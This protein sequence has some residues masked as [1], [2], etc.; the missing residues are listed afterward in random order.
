MFHTYDKEISETITKLASQG[1]NLVLYADCYTKQIADTLKILKL[2]NVFDLKVVKV[3]KYAADV[4]KQVMQNA[5]Y[6]GQIEAINKSQAVIE[7]N[8]DGTIINAN[9]NFLNTMGYSLD[10]ILGQH[11]RMFVGEKYDNSQEY[12]DFWA[13]LNRGEYQAAEYKRYGKDGKEVWIQA[14]YNPTLDPS[15]K[16]TKVVKY[17]IDITDQV[18]KNADY[19]GQIEAINKAQAVIEFKLDGTIINANENFLSVTGYTLEEV[20]GNH[21]SMFVEPEYRKSVEY[22]EFWRSL[23]N[24]EYQADEYKRLGKTGNEIWI[25]ASYNPI[26]DP[27]G[28]P[29]KVVK[30]ATDITKQVNNRHETQRVGG[31]VDSNLTQILNSVSDANIQATTAASA[32]TQTLQ[33]V[34]SVAAAVEEFQAASQEIARNM[35]LSRQEVE[36]VNTEA[37]NA[38]Q[39]CQT[40]FR[41]CV[42]NG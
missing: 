3:I 9:E 11:H 7:F 10:E 22:S 29:F 17:A 31:L 37:E 23:K 40:A 32:S 26:F 15:G 16:I 12:T 14:S 24:G 8:L 18:L 13:A 27:D 4:T 20:K 2:E 6:A 33:T 28:K 39:S 30:Y 19:S 42:S 41:C 21:H 36:K 1:Y 25:Q 38:D 34:Q 35:E 5:D